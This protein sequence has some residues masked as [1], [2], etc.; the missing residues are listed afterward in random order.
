MMG[1]YA[2][3]DPH[4]FGRYYGEIISD[5]E[6]FGAW[7][8]TVA[9][10]YADNDLVVFDTNNEYHD[11]DNTLVYQLNQAAVD[12][13]RGAGATSQYIFVEGNSWS[14]AWHWVRFF[15]FFLVAPCRLSLLPSS[16]THPSPLSL[17]G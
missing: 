16:Q 11:M 1:A 2:I 15:F 9:A 3:V 5:V 7:W 17:I 13:I 8:A 10:R 12:A 4:N 6:G 14:G